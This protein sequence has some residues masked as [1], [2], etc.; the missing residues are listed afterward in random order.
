LI[1]VEVELVLIG[2]PLPRIQLSAA[3]RILAIR[4][5]AHCP[6]VPVLLEPD[7]LGTVPIQEL[8]RKER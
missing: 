1:D 3:T 6:C 5:R 8:P 4:P 2:F 7:L